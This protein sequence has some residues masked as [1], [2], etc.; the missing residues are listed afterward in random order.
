[1]QQQ[2]SFLRSWMQVLPLSDHLRK[3]FINV[4]VCSNRTLTFQ[5]NCLNMTCSGEER[6]HH[7]FSCTSTSTNFC[8]W[9]FSLKTSH[10]GL[11]FCFGII[12][13]YPRFITCYNVENIF[14]PPSVKLFEHKMTPFHTGCLLFL[15]Q[16]MRHP[17]GASL[18]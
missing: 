18:S 15:R 2:M 4:P 12:M 14:A 16:K 6:C 8:W 11:L 7:F 13:I 9:I 3:T 10:T 17:S 5:Y 1:M